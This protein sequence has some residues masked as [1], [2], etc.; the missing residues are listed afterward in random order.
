MNKILKICISSVTEV[1]TTAAGIHLASENKQFIDD[2][3]IVQDD[4]T[5]QEEERQARKDSH[6]IPSQNIIPEVKSLSEKNETVYLCKNGQGK[7]I[8]VNVSNS[9]TST[10]RIST[11][12]AYS[13]NGTNSKNFTKETSNSLETQYEFDNN[14]VIFNTSEPDSTKP[15]SS[16]KLTTTE[17]DDDLQYITV[18]YNHDDEHEALKEIHR[19][20]ENIINETNSNLVHILKSYGFKGDP[21]TFEIPT[22]TVSLNDE[23]SDDQNT[24]IDDP[25][26]LFQVTAESSTQINQINEDRRTPEAEIVPQNSRPKVQIS[27]NSTIPDKFEIFTYNK[28]NKILEVY[29][30]NEAIH[31][32]TDAN[33]EENIKPRRNENKIKA[34][35]RFLPPNKNQLQK[36]RP[37]TE[38]PSVKVSAV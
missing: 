23:Y 15:I 27:K 16:I 34:N 1:S 37:V 17:G 36:L 13:Q 32:N 10:I 11:P 35:N 6:G 38:S 30:S 7:S 28:T 29:P 21:Y 9:P 22:T 18:Y 5:N 2:N 33:N 14:H 3:R 31:N 24:P 26:S 19:N 25:K 20:L 8:T 12:T 4:S